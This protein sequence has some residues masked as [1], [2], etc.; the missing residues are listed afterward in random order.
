MAARRGICSLLSRSLLSSS[1]ASSSSSA[2]GF[3]SF[4][5][6]H[7]ELL[8]AMVLLCFFVLC[9]VSVNCLFNGLNEVFV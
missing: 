8:L 6:S 4:L 5:Q 1:S 2:Y 3:S 9:W 7:G